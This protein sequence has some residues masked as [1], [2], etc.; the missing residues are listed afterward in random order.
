[1][2]AARGGIGREG[3]E[4]GGRLKIGDRE[5]RRK[6]TKRWSFFLLKVKKYLQVEKEG[7]KVWFSVVE[8]G[9]LKIGI[10]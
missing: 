2:L 4:G 8:R 7:R 1:M 3:G 10:R 9:G 6:T 5:W